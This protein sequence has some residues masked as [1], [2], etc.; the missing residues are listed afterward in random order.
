MWLYVLL[1]NAAVFWFH[2]FSAK[3]TL[4]E[5]FMQ[6]LDKTIMLYQKQWDLITNVAQYYYYWQ[7]SLTTPLPPPNKWCNIESIFFSIFQIWYPYERM[8]YTRVATIHPGASF[9][10]ADR[11]F[12]EKTK[13]FFTNF[14][15]MASALLCRKHCVITFNIRLS[16]VAT[17]HYL[18]SFD[19][20]GWCYEMVLWKHYSY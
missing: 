10:S 20:L 8:V 11:P 15:V 6:L 7:I 4:N 3:L 19:S 12:C 5:T 14:I 9:V 1:N 18:I 16:S 2:I 17:P 13:H